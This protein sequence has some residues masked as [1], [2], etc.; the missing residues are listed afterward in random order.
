MERLMANLPIRVELDAS[1]DKVGRGAI[2]PVRVRVTNTGSRDVW[3]V[4]NLDGS[5]AGY[6]YPHYTPRISGPEEASLGEGPFWC[7][8]V[9]PLRIEDFVRLEPGQSFDPT[10][11]SN[12]AGFQP[13]HLFSRYT[14]STPGRYELSLTISTEGASEED[15]G[16]IPVDYPGKQ[17]ISEKLQQVPRGAAESNRLIIQVE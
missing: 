1:S 15:W 6:R 10:Q 2:L 5:E 11:P 3:F 4:G 7:G 13:L 8:T 17:A 9:V 16:V 14:P 12:G